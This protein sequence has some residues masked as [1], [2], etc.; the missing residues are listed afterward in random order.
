MPHQVNE[1]AE[2][3]RKI[4]PDISQEKVATFIFYFLM[5]VL[6]VVGVFG[7]GAA[8]VGVLAS[9][10]YVQMAKFIAITV[11]RNP[12]LQGAILRI[13]HASVSLFV[14]GSV[15][16]LVA[17]VMEVKSLNNE[18]EAEKKCSDEVLKA[19]EDEI[20]KF[21]DVKEAEKKRLDDALKA[22]EVEIKKMNDDKEDEIKKMKEDREATDKLI[23][24]L[25]SRVDNLQ[26]LVSAM[27]A[28]ESLQRN[29]Q[30]SVDPAQV[31]PDPEDLDLIF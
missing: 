3:L 20:K 24:A 17:G 14:G 26:E 30:P 22:K 8:L 6:G 19:K 10:P 29:A 7:G 1:A 5:S 18:K 2:Q 21:N 31:T 16:G 23:M 12:A 28:R 25:V 9:V 13:I 27:N 11:L 15:T 4:A